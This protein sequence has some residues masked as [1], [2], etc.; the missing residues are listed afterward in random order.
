METT[1]NINLHFENLNTELYEWYGLQ[2]FD[3]LNKIFNENLFEYQGEELEEKLDELREEWN[4]LP[5]EDR[6]DFYNM[7]S[8]NEL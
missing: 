6:L 2:G 7:I 4:E 5:I 3:V 8:Y 1:F